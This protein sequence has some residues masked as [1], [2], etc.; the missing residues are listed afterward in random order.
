M[1]N[2]AY[3]KIEFGDN[4]FRNLNLS[5]KK[6]QQRISYIADGGVNKGQAYQRAIKKFGLELEKGLSENSLFTWHEILY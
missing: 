5:I 3:S 6:S 4:L 1:T 2:L